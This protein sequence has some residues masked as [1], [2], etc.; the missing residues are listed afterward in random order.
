MLC[1]AIAEVSYTS[2]IVLIIVILIFLLVPPCHLQPSLYYLDHYYFNNGY[3]S[4]FQV[5]M[6]FNY[7]TGELCAN[8]VTNDTANLMCKNLGYSKLSEI[9]LGAN[10][11]IN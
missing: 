6:C 3:T 9:I 10:D 11:Y 1:F 8:G 7:T 2:L 4:T 5:G